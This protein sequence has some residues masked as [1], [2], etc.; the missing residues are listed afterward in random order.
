MM[1]RQNSIWLM[2]LFALLLQE[3]ASAQSV[4][5]NLQ[6][7][8]TEMSS[9]VESLNKI[10]ADRK[11][12]ATDADLIF[13]LAAVVRVEEK[14]LDST[15]AFG[16]ATMLK[17]TAQF[18]EEQKETLN[19]LS[20]EQ[21]NATKRFNQWWETFKQRFGQT[22]TTSLSRVYDQIH[23]NNM[24]T[25][26]P[27][28]EIQ[29]RGNHLSQAVGDLKQC[30]TILRQALRFL[31]DALG[32]STD[33]LKKNIEQLKELIRLQKELLAETEPLEDKSTPELNEAFHN[34]QMNIR[35]PVEAMADSF[36][37]MGE[38]ASVPLREALPVME[39]SALALKQGRFDDSIDSQGRII[40]LLEHALRLAEA[41][42]V[43]S[44]DEK[45]PNQNVPLP[46]FKQNAL[47]R[48]LQAMMG[49]GAAGHNP[50]AEILNDLS[51]LADLRKQQSELRGLTAAGSTVSATASPSLSGTPPA[52][53]TANPEKQR[54]LSVTA[55]SLAGRVSSYE[56]EA[57]DNI[58]Q[59]A[60]QM[61]QAS[62]LMEESQNLEAV[63][64][65]DESL[66][67][68]DAAEELIQAF[69]DLL[70]QAMMDLMQESDSNAISM[71]ASSGKEL[72]EATRRE[73][74]AML[75]A[76]VRM[77]ALRL[78]Q[79]ALAK[80]VES[81]SDTGS[82]TQPLSLINTQIACASDALSIASM[83]LLDPHVAGA[84]HG[85]RTLMMGAKVQLEIKQWASAHEHQ[86]RAIEGIRIVAGKSN[87]M[88]AQ[89]SSQSKIQVDGVQVSGTA[90]STGGEA[91]GS[92]EGKGWI[93][94][95]PER[96][97]EV[98]Q[99]TLSEPI[100][101]EYDSLIRAYFQKLAERSTPEAQP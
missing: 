91:S 40:T 66:A 90:E 87:T 51:A 9:V 12:A 43:E 4:D 98:V 63:K 11:G 30:I 14:L 80:Q 74:M 53:A 88:L 27:G 81:A 68:L 57:A 36:E 94:N 45:G 92:A 101:A 70:L 64:S 71:G 35:R 18:T 76:M 6:V 59:A 84:L 97:R 50:L 2:G 75:R 21:A 38:S 86:V 37:A 44:P 39:F 72:D 46:P 19:K 33:A 65:Q 54:G 5:Q 20:A 69:Y 83:P 8:R 52:A 42:L 32:K 13:S 10:I 26:I 7:A 49:R 85:I 62:G 93:W 55:L 28:I 23:K 48:A 79:I 16:R 89:M 78:K 17:T 41:S 96:E 3:P 100:P 67:R 99:Q 73:M 56:D 15:L 24:E 22:P 31:E 34:R 82:A 95:L 61:E 29:L 77:N 47:K 1:M 25:L 60:K 58:T